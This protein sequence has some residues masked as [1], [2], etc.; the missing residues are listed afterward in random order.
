MEEKFDQML[1]NQTKML[2]HLTVLT[3]DVNELKIGQ[4]RLEKGQEELKVRVTSLE[5][6]QQRLEKG[7][8]ELKGKVT[9]LEEGQKRIE[10][11]QKEI[12][13]EQSEIRHELKWLHRDYVRTRARV[14]NLEEAQLQNVWENN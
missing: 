5:E 11:Y 7:Q 2:E 13:N 10:K 14:D 6:G 9:V 8:E 3:K 1:H 4:K 12:R